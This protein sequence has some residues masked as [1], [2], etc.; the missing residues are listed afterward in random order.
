MSDIFVSYSIEDSSEG[1]SISRLLEEQ[2][3]SVFWDPVIPPG[4]TFDQVIWEALRAAK[5]VIVLW[6]ARSVKST[7]VRAEA[8][9]AL[10][11]DK[12]ISILLDDTRV[13]LQFRSLQHFDLS[14]WRGDPEDKNIHHLIAAVRTLVLPS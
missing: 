10:Q 12:I 14:D 13:P 3:Y 2:G 5:C 1:R 7:W 6:S 4:Q 8:E 9:E 11:H